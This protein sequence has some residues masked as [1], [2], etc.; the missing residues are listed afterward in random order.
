MARD[1]QLA[2]EGFYAVGQ[3]DEAR[4]FGGVGAAEAIVADGEVQV[5]AFGPGVDVDTG[6]LR[7]FGRVREC[8]CR[9]VIRGY[10]GRL[11]YPVG[12]VQIQF[13]RDG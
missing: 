12:Q 13:D 3:A 5:R 6:C 4:P 8:F 11:R 2:A 7:I 1:L 9:N 10:F